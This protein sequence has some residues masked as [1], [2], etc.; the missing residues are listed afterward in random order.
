MNIRRLDFARLRQ[1]FAERRHRGLVERHGGRKFRQ[2][3]AEREIQPQ[4]PLPSP[5]P[6]NYEAFLPVS[7]PDD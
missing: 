6:Q 5:P 4:R 1:R 2:L 3:R 7:L